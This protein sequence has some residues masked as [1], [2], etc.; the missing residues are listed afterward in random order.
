V[1]DKE[2]NSAAA[3]IH[4]L[5]GMSVLMNISRYSDCEPAS[6]INVHQIY[7]QTVISS[8]R[9]VFFVASKRYFKRMR[10]STLIGIPHKT[11]SWLESF[12][13]WLEVPVNGRRSALLL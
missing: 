9:D 11:V 6:S 7:L 1:C 12:C 10:R 4:L 8:T 3:I 13:C 5:S 2:T